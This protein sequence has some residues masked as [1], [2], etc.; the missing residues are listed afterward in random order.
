MLQQ[1]PED[2]DPIY[3]IEPYLFTPLTLNF[4]LE[5]ING[6]IS[7]DATEG[8]ITI[9]V[10]ANLAMINQNF[11]SEYVGCITSVEIGNLLRFVNDLEMELESIR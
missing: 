11:P 5:C 10:M 7:D 3:P 4:E 6:D 2:T 1:L 9:R 8:E